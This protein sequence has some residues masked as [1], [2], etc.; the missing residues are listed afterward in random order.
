M[1]APRR[2]RRAGWAVT[3]ALAAATALL[4]ARYFTLDPDTFLPEQRAVYL[5]HLTPLLFHVGGGV[6]ALLLGPWQFL[7][8]LR[9]RR[10]AVHRFVGRAY[11]VSALAAGIGGLLL[12]PR[13]LVAP[14]APIG[15][16]LLAVLLL[17]TSTA[18]YATARRREFA[19]HRIWTTRSYAL[20]LAAVTLRLWL[21]AFGALGV[22]FEQAYASAAWTS[23][24]INLLVAELVVAGA[25]VTVARAEV[26]KGSSTGRVDPGGGDA[27]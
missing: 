8:G 4:G 12:A 21:V 1:T 2:L 18:A 23:W 26:R 27:S 9:T 17:A 19:R 11:L 7:P 6:L 10:P 3:T 13:A 5:A 20:I 22:S 14:I 16:A 24:L 25:G 15:F